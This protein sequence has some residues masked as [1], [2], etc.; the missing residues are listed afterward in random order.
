MTAG[1]FLRCASCVF[2][3]TTSLN[4]I[5]PMV[6][7]RALEIG[8]STAQIGYVAASYA[9]LSFVVAVPTGQWVDRFGES[10][11]LLG[12]AIVMTAMAAWLAVV[13]SVLMLGV[14]QAVLGAGQIFGLV[15]LQTLVANCSPPDQRDARYGAF[16][17]MGSLG[18][19]TGPAVGGFVSSLAGGGT[20]TA[21]WASVTFLVGLV[22]LAASLRRWPPPSG[23]REKTPPRTDAALAAM[24]RIL[25]L[26]SMPQAMLASLAVLATID[27]LVAYVPVYGE[28]NGISVAAVGLLLS[29]RAAAS[30]LSRLALVPLLRWLGRRH[31]FLLGLLLPGLA[32]LL[33]PTTTSVPLLGVLL[34]V[35]GFGLGLGQPMSLAW[36]TRA[37]PADSR[38]IAIG[39]RLMGN[40]GGQVALPAAF[41]AIGGAAGVAAIFVALG[42]LLASSAGVVMR[43]PF[44][45]DAGGS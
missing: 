18:Q 40:R 36:V 30:V 13:S 17:V 34:A 11:F 23:V 35:A 45:A 37:V 7:Y 5:R 20:T 27:I 3:L 44:D 2:L 33:F 41:G 15:A 28:A 29:L 42:V 26:R 22:V 32:L 1:W 21:L 9:L 24:V 8:A 16:A 25:R 31:L 19:V 4:V 12:G 43:A 10:R 6:S 38:G 39:V 14:A